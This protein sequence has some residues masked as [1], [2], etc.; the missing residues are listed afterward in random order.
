M[1]DAIDLRRAWRDTLP[2]ADRLGADLLRSWSAPDRAYHDAEHL[3]EVLTALGELADAVP[4]TV[5][6]AAWFHDAVYD[7]RRD[8]NEER[9]AQLAAATLPDAGVDPAD[10]A[11][12]ERLVRLTATHDPVADDADGILLCDADLA[13]LG[14]SPA[15]YARYVEDVRREYAHVPEPDFRTARGRILRG[16]LARPAIYRTSRGR[17]RWESAARRNLRAELGDGDPPPAAA[18]PGPGC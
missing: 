11:E 16:F 10:V 3:A 12:V 1:N 5:R 15:R 2:G 18:P 14:A 4:R 9:S 6:L 7:P 13:I 8:D 17:D